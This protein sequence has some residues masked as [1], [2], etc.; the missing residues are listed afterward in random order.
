MSAMGLMLFSTILFGYL[1]YLTDWSHELT[2]AQPPELLIMVVLLK[3]TLRCG[4]LALGLTALTALWRPWLAVRLAAWCELAIAASFIAVAVWDW[5]TPQY[6]SGID[7]IVLLLIAVLMLFI[8]MGDL[9]PGDAGGAAR[10][11]GGTPQA[12]DESKPA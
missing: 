2:N 7:P 3:W 12:G 10:G 11:R 5:T 9:R 4:A 1:G 6:S 8:A